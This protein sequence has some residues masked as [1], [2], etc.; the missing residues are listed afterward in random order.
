MT[1]ET[2][3]MTDSAPVRVGLAVVTVWSV[4]P[5]IIWCVLILTLRDIHP[6]INWLLGQTMF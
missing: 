4:E 5:G 3:V 1:D 6:T 2:A